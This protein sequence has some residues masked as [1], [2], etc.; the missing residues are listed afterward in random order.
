MFHVV[1]LRSTL[2][3]MRSSENISA[4][5]RLIKPLLST[6]AGVLKIKAAVLLHLPIRFGQYLDPL[7]EE[8]HK[9]R[10]LVLCLSFG[11]DESTVPTMMESH[12][13]LTDHF[14]TDFTSGGYYRRFGCGRP[15]FRWYF[16][17]CS[18]S[19]TCVQRGDGSSVGSCRSSWKE[20][21]KNCLAE[22][23]IRF[24]DEGSSALP[25]NIRWIYWSGI[26][27][28]IADWRSVC[29]W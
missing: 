17:R 6:Q 20:Y 25:N 27:S 14:G 26:C 13:A 8:H 10:H 1:N 22:M 2:L 24:W 29:R 18:R 12:R 23:N 7:K 11:V 28:W 9:A 3:L 15:L 19:D 16:V 4:W 21:W 5:L